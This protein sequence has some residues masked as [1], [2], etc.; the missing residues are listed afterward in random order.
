MRLL[1][2][3]QIG[4]DVYYDFWSDGSL[5]VYGS[6]PAYN[7]AD[8]FFYYGV[9]VHSGTTRITVESGVTSLPGEAFAP[10]SGR[11]YSISFPDTLVSLSEPGR[12]YGRYLEYITVDPANPAFASQNGV[13]YN[14]DMTELLCYPNEL[15]GD[16]FTVPATV[17]KIGDYAMR[18]T[19][20][21]TAVTL[22]NGLETVGYSGLAYSA[23]RS[24]DFGGTLRQ[25]GDIAFEGCVNL[26]EVTLPDS[27]ETLGSAVFNG[28]TSLVS[29][30]FGS[31]ITSIPYHT[32][33]GCTSLTNVSIPL[34]VTAIEDNAFAGAVPSDVWYG[35]SA[36]TWKNISVG[37][38]NQMLLEATFHYA[39]ECVDPSGHSPV[40][41]PETQPTYDM[42]GCT[43]GVYCEKCDTWLSGHEV[44]H[45]T[46]GAREVLQQPTTEE[47]GS[48]IITCTECGERGL[49]AIERLEYT[50][51]EEEPE[52]RPTIIEQVAQTL[53]KAV[54]SV[55]N[56]ILRLVKWLGKK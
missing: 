31:G 36:A 24:I 25:I 27:V 53:Q 16:T 7:S 35:G 1:E 8:L 50:E 45:N 13:L 42:H 22:P 48:V 28:C 15:Q 20:K 38:N 46:F 34:S 56:W 26:T 23:V 52:T 43:A 54:N 14:K 33:Y 32:L 40:Q 37:S 3:V 19:Q 49:Y 30:T 44:I 21:L 12:L 55:V 4:D 10:F 29:F 41:Y 18:Y 17:K 11:I 47:E 2:G 9:G 51:P 6:G 5:N 39:F